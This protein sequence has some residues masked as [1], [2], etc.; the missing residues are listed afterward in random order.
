MKT[1]ESSNGSYYHDLRR[2]LRIGV[3]FILISLLFT[4]RLR[5]IVQQF[6]NMFGRVRSGYSIEDVDHVPIFSEPDFDGV[7]VHTVDIKRLIMFLVVFFSLA[8]PFL[9]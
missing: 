7:D 8:I 4:S 6:L 5:N 1:T 3:L 9:F 2:A